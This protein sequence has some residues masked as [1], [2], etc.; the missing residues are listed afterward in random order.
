MLKIIL[1]VVSMLLFSIAQADQCAYVSKDQA[2]AALKAVQKAEDVDSLCQP[3]GE[4]QAQGIGFNTAEAKPVGSENFWGLYLD[5]R[6]T[7]LAYTYVDG[8]NL[9]A[10]VGCETMYVDYELKK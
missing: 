8:K 9:A 10:I 6:L 7:D 1:P 4:T 2:Q 5:G 3:C